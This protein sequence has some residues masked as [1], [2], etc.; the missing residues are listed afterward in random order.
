MLKRLANDPVWGAGPSAAPLT[1]T[2]FGQIEPRLE[3]RDFVAGLLVEGGFVLVYGESNCGKTFW[4][5][6]LALHVA[7]GLPWNGRR[8]DGGPVV[9]AAL[10]GG[11]GFR[12]RLA[13]WRQ[14][15]DVR[16]RVPFAAI[17]AALDLRD[18]E[19][20]TERLIEAVQTVA[21]QAGQPVRMLVVDTM[22]RAMAG[23]DE[24][25]ASDMSSLIGNVDRIR[26]ETGACVV[27]VHHCGKDASRGARGHSSL[28]AAADTEIEVRSDQETG[29]RT[30]T[31]SKQ[32]DLATGGSFNFRLEAV[33]LGQNQHGEDVTTCTVRGDMAVP[34]KLGAKL[35]PEEQG[36][37]RDVRAFFDDPARAHEGVSPAPGSAPI[38]AATR[39]EMR[40][41][42]VLRG[43]VGSVT[44]PGV[45]RPVTQD[46][47]GGSEQGHVTGALHPPAALSSA[48]RQ[49]LLR[50]LNRLKDKGK[51][52]MFGEWIWLTGAAS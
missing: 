9:Y 52:G 38:R 44:P 31:I 12:N 29:L 46:V 25:S 50:Y 34:R 22:A 30:A 14:A 8:V 48:D 16:A 35:S 28:R 41:W 45:S 37:L 40:A 1:L 26:A 11:D 42:L 7:A 18:L 13:A 49:N 39:D 27:L 36:W 23:G 2:W 10:E 4:T 6:D 43:R 15:H 21:K 3:S 20:D 33:T 17:P 51:I 24:N 32:R 19:G 5:T 47:E